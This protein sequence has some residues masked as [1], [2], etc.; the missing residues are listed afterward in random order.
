MISQ[1]RLLENQRDAWIIHY[2]ARINDKEKLKKMADV[3]G[4]MLVSSFCKDILRGLLGEKVD[5]EIE[6]RIFKLKKFSKRDR[7]RVNKN[8]GE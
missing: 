6:S 1:K 7:G 5:E 4:P 2:L 3:Y 8:K